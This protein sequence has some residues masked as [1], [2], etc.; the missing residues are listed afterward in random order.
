[1][2]IST[3][4][5]AEAWRD[6]RAAQAPPHHSVVGDVRVLPDV[7]SPQLGNRRRLWLYL[8][9]SYWRSDRRYPVFYFQDGQNLFDRATSYAGEEWGLDET[10]EALSGEGREAIAVGVDHAG[11]QRLPEYNP[12]PGWWEARGE[13]YVSFLAETVKPL[14]DAGFRTRPEREHTG[15][16]GSSLGGLISLY[17]FFRRPDLFSRVGALS[18][19]LWPVRGAIYDYVRQAPFVDG[20]VYLDNGTRENNARPMYDLLK[21]KGYR[22]RRHLKYVSEPGG[23]H[24]E[25]AWARRLPEALRFLLPNPV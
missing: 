19:A 18:P 16:V 15:V 24:R 3:L 9:P 11:E 5:P 2:S 17:A 21:A 23:E 7:H 22:P 13:A 4:A 20:R 1:M 25:S 10:L 12:F 6:Y 8:P 14:I